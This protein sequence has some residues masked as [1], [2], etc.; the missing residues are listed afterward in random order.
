MN[1]KQTDFSYKSKIMYAMK[2]LAVL[3]VITAHCTSVSVCENRFGIIISIFCSSVGTI[4]VAIFFLLSGYFFYGTKRNFLNFFAGKIKT[5]LIPWI[6]CGTLV[7]LYV[8]LRG[9]RITL[10]SLLRWLTGYQTYLYYLPVLIFLYL[11]LFYFRK[12]DFV[13]YFIIFLS[14]MSL[15]LTQFDFIKNINPYLNPFNFAIWFVLG[16]LISRYDL[17]DFL[18][19]ISK[20][21]ALVT[22][23]VYLIVI[24]LL[25]ANNKSLTYFSLTYVLLQLIAIIS[26]IGLS[27][28][29]LKFVENFVI[30][31]GK[32][33][34]A[35]YL[36][37]M[38]F[39]GMVAFMF[40][41]FLVNG[42][43]ILIILRPIITLAITY[44]FM[45]IVSFVAE[46]IR[47]SALLKT[48]TA[49]NM[50]NR[51]ES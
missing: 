44:L 40:N 21:F 34:Y 24:A 18:L 31:L 45:W 35:I 13:L 28:L 23:L 5:I 46:K 51:K 39:A 33:S 3:S 14:L 19:T 4:G 8:Y 11:I 12:A 26:V 49:I 29:V 20:K 38:P 1:I 6:F 32:N 48:L 50:L 27:N 36:L 42:G 15:V 47:L 10:V 22:S 41:R 17:F 16:V 37:H 25:A 2:V 9:G 7:Y 43:G 30:I